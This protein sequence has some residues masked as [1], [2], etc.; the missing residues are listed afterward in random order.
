[1]TRV[2]LVSDAKIEGFI[3]VRIVTGWTL[4][5]FKCQEISGFLKCYVDN[6]QRPEVERVLAQGIT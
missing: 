6:L 5:I 3:L 1:M 2:F 4:D